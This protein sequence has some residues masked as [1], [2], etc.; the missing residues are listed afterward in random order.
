MDKAAN[1]GAKEDYAVADFTIVSKPVAIR[2]ECPFCE[3]EIEIPWREVEV[4]ENW[5]DNWPAVACPNC[6]KEIALDDWDYD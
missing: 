6:G 1:R 2:L 4:P 3:E 5:S